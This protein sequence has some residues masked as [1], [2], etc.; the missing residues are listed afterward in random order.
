MGIN[1]YV[2]SVLKDSVQTMSDKDRVLCL[3]FDKMSISICISIRRLTIEDSEDLG[4]HSRTNNI[5][6]HA[7]VFML[8]GL[9]KRCKQPVA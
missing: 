9:H 5:A 2:F 1:A 6:N 4:S 3:M 7:L 8:C